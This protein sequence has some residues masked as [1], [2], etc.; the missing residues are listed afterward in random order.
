MHQKT[1]N[2][3]ILHSLTGIVLLLKH[4]HSFIPRRPLKL[5]VTFLWFYDDVKL[6]IAHDCWFLI[7]LYY[8]IVAFEALHCIAIWCSELTLS[9]EIERIRSFH[10]IWWRLCDDLTAIL[11]LILHCILT[12]SSWIHWL[13][14]WWISLFKNTLLLYWS[15]SSLVIIV[16]WKLLISKWLSR[17]FIIWTRKPF[18]NFLR[19]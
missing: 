6:L 3:V 13:V 17:F 10:M 4:G 9:Q 7:L 14:D 8:S 1:L 2:S 18:Y 15:G 19:A 12:F 16:T 5:T 11:D